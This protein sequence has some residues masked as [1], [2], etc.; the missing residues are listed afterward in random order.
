MKS[1]RLEVR[2]I[3]FDSN[4]NGTDMFPLVLQVPINGRLIALSPLSIPSIST[5]AIFILTDRFQYAAISYTTKPPT[6]PTPPGQLP[7]VSAYPVY[8]HAS[9]SLETA[10]ISR[11]SEG[12]TIVAVD[13]YN[14]CIA[15]HAFDGLL[16]ILPV[17]LNYQPPSNA[18]SDDTSGRANHRRPKQLLGTPFHCRVEES[19]ILSIAFLYTNSPLGSN[20]SPP[21]QIAVLHQDSR[22]LQHLTTHVVNLQKQQIYLHG[23]QSAPSSVQWM[24]KSMIDGGSSMLIPVKLPTMATSTAR[25]TAADTTTPPLN[26]STPSNSSPAVVVVGQRQFTYCSITATKIMPVPQSLF[27]AY[28]ELPNDPVTDM[29]RYLLADEL[30]TLHILSFVTVGDRVVA[31]QLEALG[32][33]TLASTLTYLNDGMLYVGST[34]GDSQLIQIHDDPI[35]Q[36]NT[37]GDERNTEDQEGG[38][39][40]ADTT[41]LSV[42]EEYT[43]LGPILDFDLVPTTPQ[44]GPSARLVQSQVVTA[45]GTSKSGSIRIVRNGIGMYEHASVDIPGIQAMWSLRKSYDTNDDTYLVQ[46]FVG[47]TR[48]LGVTTA[49]SDDVMTDNNDD[50]NEEHQVGSAL[51]EVILPGLVSTSSTLYVGNVQDGDRLLQITST[52]IRL[53]TH[54]G[55]IVCTWK[56]QITIAAANEAGQIAVSVQGG[57]LVYFVIDGDSL[58]KVHEKQLDSEVSSLDIHPFHTDNDEVNATME[59]DGTNTVKRRSVH[60]SLVAVGLWDDFT[61][62]LLSIEHSLNEVVCINLGSTDEDEAMDDEITKNL[63]RQNRNNMMA[64]SLCLVSLDFTTTSTSSTSIGNDVGR[65]R[66][67]SIN[68]LFI[69]MGD[70]TLV[71]FAVVLVES[72]VSVQSK[73]EVC[74]G[75]QRIDLVRL[76]TE[77]GGTCVLATGDRPT[78]IYLAGIVGSGTQITPKLCYSNVN[79]E[80]IHDEYSDQVGSVQSKQGLSVNVAT[81]FFSPLLFNNLFLGKQQYSLCVADNLQLKLGVI[82]DIQKL[83]VTTCHLGMAPRRIVHCPEGRLY[84]VGCIESGIQNFGFSGDES[85]MGNCI[86]FLDETSFDDLEKITLEPYEMILSMAYVSLSVP[87]SNKDSTDKPSSTNKDIVL[88]PFLLVGTAYAFPD[89]DEPTRGRILAYSCQPDDASTAASFHERPIRQVAELS[90]EGGVYCMCQFYD[91]KI[92]VTVNSKTHVC[93]LVEEVGLLQLQYLGLGHFGHILSLFVKSR[94]QHKLEHAGSSSF[95]KDLPL[96]SSTSGENSSENETRKPEEMLAVVGDLMRSISLVQ[97]YPEHNTLEEI[98]RDFNANWTCAVEMLNEN[99][100]I[101][102][103]NWNNLFCLRR[104]TSSSNEEIRCR[105]DTIGEFHLGEMCNKFMSGSLVMPVSSKTATSSRRQVRRPGS[106]RKVST[107]STSV[108]TPSKGT[109]TALMNRPIVSTG[110]QTLFGTVDGT[111]GVILG[112]DSRT[113]AFFLSLEKAMASI[114]RPVGDFTHQH[115]RACHAER[116]IHPAHGFVDGD[117]TESFL[118]MDRDTMEL[119]VQEMNRDGSWD[120]D[121]TRIPSRSGVTVGDANS[122]SGLHDEMEIQRY[123]LSVEDVLA[124]VEEM[125]MIH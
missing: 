75:T 103:E 7:K 72:T 15:V 35:V 45:S 6:I 118:D 115:Y 59:V 50:D 105:L 78:V 101:G 120:V 34:F 33:T 89:E 20:E 71:S 9:G 10:N 113:G 110:S 31:M 21:I 125:T 86:R 55:D 30:G 106:P 54:S 77:H 68:M 24:K 93:Q 2:Q 76:S 91:G 23:S 25:T 116:R 5:S 27:L 56:G 98:A 26:S 69:G 64:R 49:A 102:A 37:T 40:L 121:D 85:N 60:S 1:A 39:V 36:Q 43:N 104:N 111:L 44:S 29:P 3:R 14:R 123:T 84:A 122:N 81:P 4:V 62:R 70:G 66:S 38:D 94:A 87:L 114:I 41:F 42:V 99:I 82:D 107:S 57:M 117:L 96:P 16:T 52:E 65:E 63:S 17:D 73:K 74:L 47:E 32:S 61:V 112:L 22:G 97:F 95:V 58:Q 90:T 48:V 88:R 46:S 79:V 100:Y 119:I 108:Q 80:S 28:T 11:P 19:T 53:F 124:M 67:S 92:L 51:E 18:K 109:M 12:G 83:H 13:P 8:T